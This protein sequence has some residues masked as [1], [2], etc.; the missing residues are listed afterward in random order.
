MWILSHSFQVTF[1]FFF[2]TP[3][4]FMSPVA[5]FFPSY[6]CGLP[7]LARAHWSERVILDWYLLINE[8]LGITALCKLSNEELEETF[9]I[10]HYLWQNS[11]DYRTEKFMEILTFPWEITV[12]RTNHEGYLKCRKAFLASL[13]LLL[14]RRAL[15]TCSLK[16][17]LC[18]R[19]N[20]SRYLWHLLCLSNELE[21]HHSSLYSSLPT[22]FLPHL[23]LS[24]KYERLLSCVNCLKINSISLSF[25]C[26]EEKGIL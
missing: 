15:D 1:C 22:I 19:T 24:Y 8:T 7:C 4:W 14:V 2:S 9:P 13:R 20:S 16:L 12:E 6:F 21:D 18:L 25:V 3:V 10:P 11:G 23:I 17:A 5:S 26:R